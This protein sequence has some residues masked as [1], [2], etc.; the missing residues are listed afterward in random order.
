MNF[1]N[2]KIDFA[3]KKIF[4]NEQH[5]EVL[6]SFL[7]AILY[8]GQPMI[9][10]LETIMDKWLYFMRYASELKEIPSVMKIEPAID[11]A[12]QIANRVNLSQEELDELEKRE[13]FVR[14]MYRLVEVA[15]QKAEEKG[16]K[17]GKKEKAIEIALQ[18]LDV[19]ADE[20]I[21]EKTGLTLDE[22]RKL[23]QSQSA[24]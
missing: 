18:F 17:E 3:F 15:E 4:G 11:K 6:I 5:K 8:V 24:N 12:F 7:N 22:V 19:V 14:D 13:F 2:P 20:I 9:E 16:K 10:T 1:I 21:S 23:G